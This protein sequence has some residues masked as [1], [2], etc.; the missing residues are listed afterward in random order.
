VTLKTNKHTHTHIYI[1]ILYKSNQPI[2]IRFVDRE[3]N[4]C[5]C[6]L[7][8]SHFWF[9]VWSSVWPADKVFCF[10]QLLMM[11]YWF[12]VLRNS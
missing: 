6:V 9:P 7:L 12:I 5:V 1:Y 8:C 3:I 2:L 11:M 4:I 10:V